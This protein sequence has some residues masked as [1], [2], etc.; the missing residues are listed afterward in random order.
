M[1]HESSFATA[2]VLAAA[3]ACGS[4]LAVADDPGVQL[5]GEQITSVFSGHKISGTT[6]AGKT[7]T[8]DYKADGT[9]EWSGGISGK[10]W[11]DG[12]QYCDQPANDKTYCRTIYKT[13]E[14]QYQFY[15]PDGSK[16]AA[17]TLE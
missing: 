12:N 16:G 5:K 9:V 7:F 4:T 8:G 13:G 2:A 3:L 17:L 1:K 6:P 14:K 11:V 15:R 10:W